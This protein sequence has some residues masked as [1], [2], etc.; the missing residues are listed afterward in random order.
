MILHRWDE[1]RKRNVKCK[2]ASA[3]GK[4]GHIDIR[5]KC[6]SEEMSTVRTQ[7]LMAHEG[8]A[9]KAGHLELDVAHPSQSWKAVVE[10]VAS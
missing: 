8:F 9:N 2:S 4:N 7:W 1:I 6:Y 5:N 3:A 10:R